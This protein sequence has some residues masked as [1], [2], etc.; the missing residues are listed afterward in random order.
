M[1]SLFLF[2]HFSVRW[3]HKGSPYS[4]CHRQTVCVKLACNFRRIL[5]SFFLVFRS[6]LS[7]SNNA[8]FSRLQAMF[9][10]DYSQNQI[11]QLKIHHFRAFIGAEQSSIY[12]LLSHVRGRLQ[13]CFYIRYRYWDLIGGDYKNQYQHFGLGQSVSHIQVKARKEDCIY[14]CRKA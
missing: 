4:G 2:A 13:A 7:G 1:T 8:A 14:E 12:A 5:L 6:F 10:G 9:G 3:G 11:L